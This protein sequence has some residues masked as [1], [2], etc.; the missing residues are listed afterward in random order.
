M[1]SGLS[2]HTTPALTKTNPGSLLRGKA[3]KSPN[4]FHPDLC[5]VATPSSWKVPSLSHPI[6]A[7]HK[8]HPVFPSRPVPL[9]PSASPSSWDTLAQSHPITAPRKTIQTCVPQCPQWFCPTPSL[10][11]IKSSNVF[12]PALCPP[13]PPSSWDTHA[14][15]H[16]IPAQYKTIQ[17]FPSRSVYPHIPK[18]LENPGFISPHPCST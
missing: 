11:I 1:G 9:C 3:Q 10:L 18:L 15:S 5:P 2:L 13:A 14:L 16:P 7:Q 6:T 12:Y 8:I 4:F 17:P